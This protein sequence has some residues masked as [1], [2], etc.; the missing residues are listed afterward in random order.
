MGHQYF[1]NAQ[2]YVVV[3]S[4]CGPGHLPEVGFTPE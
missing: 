1:L 4:D 2:Y 3:G